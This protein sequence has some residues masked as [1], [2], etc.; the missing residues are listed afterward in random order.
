MTAPTIEE[1]VVFGPNVE[2]I[3]AQ[4]SRIVKGKIP[5]QVRRELMAA[6]KTKQLGRFE[7]DGLLPEVFYHP[8]HKH[9]ACER[10]KR[11]AEYAISC[12]ETVMSA[13]E[14]CRY[15]TSHEIAARFS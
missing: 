2:L 4:A 8:D 6:V 12:I 5:A 10:R 9:G 1:R 7:K 14:G 11:E 3:R 15:V 13:D